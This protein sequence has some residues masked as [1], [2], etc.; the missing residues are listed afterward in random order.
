[1]ASMLKLDLVYLRQSIETFFT[2]KTPLFTTLPLME[3]LLYAIPATQEIW[4]FSL[5]NMYGMNKV[6]GLVEAFDNESRTKL[7]AGQ[8]KV[9]DCF[10]PEWANLGQAFG[11]AASH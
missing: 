5:T 11:N 7:A 4:Q 6:Y 8:L 9:N 10:A 3:K 1:M 2:T